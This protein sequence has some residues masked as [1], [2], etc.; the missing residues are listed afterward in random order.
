MAI[1]KIN[2]CPSNRQLRQFG[3]IALAALPLAGWLLSGRPWPAD[4]S[5][6][7]ALAI[8]GLAAI[9]AFF[10]LA[11]VI[12]PQFLRVPF[13]V[14]SL[15]ALPIGLVFSEVILLAM[16]F[17]LFVPVGLIFRLIGRDALDRK[18]ER[19]AKSY[20]QPKTP[21]AGLESYFRQS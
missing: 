5:Q 20:W 11:A 17:L 16:Y 13:V 9:G 21:P 8:G 7:Q 3:I 1:V 14:L 19:T 10:A 2:W 18:I 4:T 15:L 6:V 12:R